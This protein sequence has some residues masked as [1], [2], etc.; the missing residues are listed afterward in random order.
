MNNVM[1][2][3]VA[4]A[5][6]V[7]TIACIKK[8]KYAVAGGQSALYWVLGIAGTIL[9]TQ[10]LVLWADIKGAS[11]GLAISFV[12]VSVMIAAAI[13]G[14]DGE[15]GRLIVLPLKHIPVLESTGYVLAVVGV[16]LVG[17]SQQRQSVSPQ[18]AKHHPEAG[19]DI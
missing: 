9:A 11:L 17:V 15:S 1:L 6:N 4:A 8:C 7:G 5:C 10:Y 18:G 13:M 16:L 2:T 12:I 3:L 19:Q 14:V